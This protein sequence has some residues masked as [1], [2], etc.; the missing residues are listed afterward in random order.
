MSEKLSIGFVRGLRHPRLISSAT[1]IADLSALTLNV[2]GAAL[3]FSNAE[4]ARARTPNVV[5]SFDPATDW[6]DGATVSVSLTTPPVPAKPAGLKAAAGDAQVALSWTD[7]GDA[8]ITRY[9]YQ[10]KAGSAAWGSWTDIPDSAP[11]QA[12]A[13]SYTVASLRNGTA[14][15][16]RIR[17]VNIDGNGAQSDE[18]GPVTAGATVVWSATLTADFQDGD[19][20]CKNTSIIDDCSSPSVLTDDNF[21]YGGATYTVTQLWWQYPNQLRLVLDGAKHATIQTRF[22]SLALTVDGN[23]LHVGDSSAG[24][25]SEGDGFLSWYY[26]PGTAQWTDGQSVSLSLAEAAPAKA[27]GLTATAGNAQVTLFWNDPANPSITKYQY[28]QKEGSAAWPT[29]WTDIPDSAPGEAN[30]ASYTVAGLR[31]VTTYRFRVRAVNALGVGPQSDV[32]GPVTPA[33]PR[34]TVWSETLTV[35]HRGSPARGCNNAT[36]NLDDCSSS[37]VLTDDDF[38]H[39]GAT[40]TVNRLTWD[41][42]VKTLWLGFEVGGRAAKKAALSSLTLIVD[43]TALA[44]AAAEIRGDNNEYLFLSYNPN[45]VWTDGQRVEVILTGPSTTGQPVHNMPT[46]RPPTPALPPGG[47]GAP[48]FPPPPSP[49]PSPVRPEETPADTEPSL[50]RRPLLALYRAAGGESWENKW[51]TDFP[52]DDWHGVRTNEDDRV[53]ELDL[54]DNGLGG[55]IEEITEE[56]GKLSYLETLDLS[57]NPDLSGELPSDLMELEN[58]RTLDIQNTG[59]C[60]PLDEAFQDWLMGITFRGEYCAEETVDQPQVSGGG[61]CSVSSDGGTG[62]GAISLFLAV[63]ALLLIPRRRGLKAERT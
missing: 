61:G 51:D 44:M 25:S 47:E 45:P 57:G 11:G 33:D 35:D 32:A 46:T 43:G 15:R 19:A 26:N 54:S 30:A 62:D 41:L 20:G 37:S 23:A 29:T 2:D 58:L 18:A 42:G 13:A 48:P 59:L 50:D 55:E 1:A 6:T 10:Q 12:N 53:T 36:S 24:E 28:Q 17:A 49:P 52:V 4:A 31:N 21:V 39:G 60:A 8:S 14:Y 34:A 16:F 38:V 22:A 63:S 3:A 56:I 7:P 9:Q 27:K 5:W 40:Y